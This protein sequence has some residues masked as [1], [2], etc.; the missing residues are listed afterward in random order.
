MR[1]KEHIEFFSHFLTRRVSFFEYFEFS[2]FLNPRKFLKA[3]LL[4]CTYA[5][6]PTDL[7]LT[8]NRNVWQRKVKMEELRA[9][10][11]ENELKGE[12]HAKENWENKFL[13][14]F[15]SAIFPFIKCN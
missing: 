13:L 14:Y 15:K 4:K 11:K 8:G 9:H 10:G 1:Y 5:F 6:S 7:S 3:L 2:F 12:K